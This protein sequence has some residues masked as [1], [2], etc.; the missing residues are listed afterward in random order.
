M[1]VEFER[2]SHEKRFRGACV[3]C[4]EEVLTPLLNSYFSEE[5]SGVMGAVLSYPF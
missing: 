5:L 1:M 4:S 3:F 2:F